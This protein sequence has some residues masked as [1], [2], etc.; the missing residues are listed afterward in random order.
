MWYAKVPRPA[1]HARRADVPA[2]RNRAFASE[3][4]WQPSI[5]QA[6]AHAAAC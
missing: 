3:T 1:D 4:P 2:F 5:P 6:F